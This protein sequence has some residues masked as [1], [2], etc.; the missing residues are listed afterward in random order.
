MSQP[1]TTRV[2]LEAVC[3]SEPI[4]N[5]AVLKTQPISAKY[6]HYQL[7]SKNA[8]V[9]VKAMDMCSLF[10]STMNFKTR[11][12]YPDANY[13]VKPNTEYSIE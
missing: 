10:C 3:C 6:N 5:I 1:I 9:L 4:Q 11:L 2:V 8:E 13:K 7:L 12:Y